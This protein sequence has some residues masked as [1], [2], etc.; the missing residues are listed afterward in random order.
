MKLCNICLYKMNCQNRLRKIPCKYIHL[1]GDD[2]SWI[3]MFC[4]D[5]RL[6]CRSKYRFN[7]PMIQNIAK[8]L[9]ICKG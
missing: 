8:I 2:S 3:Q 7:C 4:N 5:C 1:L 9:R 6:D